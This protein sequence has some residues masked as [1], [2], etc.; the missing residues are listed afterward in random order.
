MK[1]AELERILENNATLPRGAQAALTVGQLRDLAADLDVARLRCGYELPRAGDASIRCSL[2]HGHQ[3]GHYYEVP[4][5]RTQQ[6]CPVVWREADAR[7]LR[8]DGHAE[9]HLFMDYGGRLGV[10]GVQVEIE[11]E[12]LLT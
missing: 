7:C 3:G 5:R 8:M 12:E 9:P 10:R 1:P 11:A 6:R 4:V 2:Q